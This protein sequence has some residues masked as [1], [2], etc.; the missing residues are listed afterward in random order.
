MDVTS[1][2]TNIPQEEGIEVVCKAY[3]KFYSNNPPIRHVS[4]MK[5]LVLILKENSFRFN[6]E[7]FLQTH[8]TAMGTKMAV[9]FAN[10]FMAEI[11]TRIIQQSNTKPRVWNRYI[12]DILSLWDSNVQEVNHF[13]DQAN[14]LHPT[15]K[16]T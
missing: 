3:E 7:H 5:C 15:I 10:I 1:L 2:Y 14:R 8:G 13:I 16:F 11:E 6:G 12:D 9:S 4:L